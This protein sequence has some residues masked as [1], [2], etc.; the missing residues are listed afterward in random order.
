M[1]VTPSLSAASTT[2]VP[3]PDH[4][5]LVVSVVVPALNEASNMP[6]LF[7]ELSNTA[8]S[9]GMDMEILVVD[10]GSDDG[11]LEA[12][13]GAA[14]REGLAHVR[15]LRHRANRGKTAA[16]MT[17]AREATGDVIVLFDADLQY[18][19]N[20]IPRFAAAVAA[21]PDVVTGRKVGKYDKRFVSGVYNWLSRRIFGVPVRDMNSLKAFRPEVLDEI[22]LRRDWHRYLVVLAHSAGFDVAE[23]DVELHPRRHGEAKYSGG[24]RVVIGML[25]LVSVW[26]QLVFS[27]K[28]MLFFGT[29]GFM[30]IALGVVVGLVALYLRFVVQAGFRPL[31][32]LVVLLVVLGALLLMAGFVAELVAGLRSEVEELRRDL[33][34]EHH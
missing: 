4:S 16:L 1:T 31:L 5:S 19:T 24:G 32:T 6:D 13:A 30:L 22:Q 11:T 12:A 8:R 28:P 25:D 7:A 17:A 33:K 27:R 18:S 34:R 2:A 20:E 10:D 3:D 14:K 23:L 26:F 9:S 15:L 21:G 29:S